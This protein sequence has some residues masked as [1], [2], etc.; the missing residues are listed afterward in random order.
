M[1]KL[2][3]ILSIV[4]TLVILPYYAYASPNVEKDGDKV[5]VIQKVVEFDSDYFLGIDGY[6]DTSN[7]IR[8]DRLT[9]ENDVLRARLDKLTAQMEILLR[10]FKESKSDTDTDTEINPDPI[11]PNITDDLDE[12][13]DKKS[14]NNNDTTDEYIPTELDSKVHN[15]FK[16][17]CARCHNETKQSGGL[18]LF[19]RQ[20]DALVLLPIETRL[21]VHDVTNGVGLETKGLSR[22]PPNRPLLDAEVEILRQWA[23]EEAARLRLEKNEDF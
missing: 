4:T 20:T 19:N 13:I 9:E 21:N 8:Q 2:T 6:Y 11:E 5:T 22:M 15:I 12:A 17:K 18:K 10:L 14:D 16:T 1:I 7:Q 23:L 3:L